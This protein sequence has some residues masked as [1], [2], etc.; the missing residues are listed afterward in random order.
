VT[1]DPAAANLGA[2]GG[3]EDQA[4]INALIAQAQ[5]SQA[6]SSNSRYVPWVTGMLPYTGRS[7]ISPNQGDRAADQ[8]NQ[9][10]AAL[11]LD[12]NKLHADAAGQDGQL[13]NADD[14]YLDLL[15]MSPEQ[16]ATIAQQMVDAGM[17]DENPTREQ[18]ES[19]WKNLIGKAADYHDANP[20]SMLTPIDMLKLY[21]VDKDNPQ[22][23]KISEVVS[24]TRD[25][26][27]N[28]DARALLAR[29]ATDA[30]GRRPT[31]K[32]IDDLQVA[33]NDA[34]TKNPVVT[35][36]RTTLDASGDAKSQ[37]TT[38]TGGV[39][40]SAITD[41]FVRGGDNPDPN[42]EYGQYQAAS[43]YYNALLQALR[44]PVGM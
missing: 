2:L 43:T 15:R 7:P 27:S 1:V 23:P 36:T 41:K 29:A 20:N 22:S 39:D 16:F 44:G 3:P 38:R 19:V 14:V 18:V 25:L 8:A 32:E 17:L 30:L 12:P 4:A 34:Q 21:G 35:T 31:Q 13:R 28:S 24:R 9:Q 6:G 33:L 11:H 5:A 26:S 42:S 37:D 40:A 10:A